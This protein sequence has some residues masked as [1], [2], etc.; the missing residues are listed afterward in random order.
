[1]T[2][3]LIAIEEQNNQIHF[4]SNLKIC[5]DGMFLENKIRNGKFYDWDCPGRTL[6]GRSAD[7]V[8]RNGVKF[9][10]HPLNAD[11]L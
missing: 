5:T 1:M 6:D 2:Q 8:Q 11:E 10:H 3:Y 7:I 9:I 4:F